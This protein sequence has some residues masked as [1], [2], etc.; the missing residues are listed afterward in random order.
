[1]AKTKARQDLSYGSEVTLKQASKQMAVQLSNESCAAIGWKACDIA[2]VRQRP[3][4]QVD[5]LVQ[6]LVLSSALVK[7]SLA[8]SHQSV[9]T[10]SVNL[11]QL[12]SPGLEWN[13][14]QKH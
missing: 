12:A 1:M 14:F 9:L 5:G 6:S 2:L 8:L 7:P 3:G 13:W 10:E 4:S 11:P